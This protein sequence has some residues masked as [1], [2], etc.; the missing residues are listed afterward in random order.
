MLAPL[1]FPWLSI[2]WFPYGIT[3]YIIL[4]VTNLTSRR[5]AKIFAANTF[6]ELARYFKRQNSKFTHSTYHINIIL[7]NGIMWRH[8]LAILVLLECN[9]I[10]TLCLRSCHT[11]ILLKYIKMQYIILKQ[12]DSYIEY[13]INHSI[14]FCNVFGNSMACQMT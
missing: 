8:R 4:H 5:E 6:K 1:L 11:N 14:Y 13:F 9:F 3:V 10:A 12:F 7:V 2:A